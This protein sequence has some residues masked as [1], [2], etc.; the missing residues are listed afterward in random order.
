MHSYF[1]V[2]LLASVDVRTPDLHNIGR[3]IRLSKS[4]KAP[5]IRALV[6]QITVARENDISPT[7]APIGYTC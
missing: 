1:S 2:S 5:D 7:S 6:L 4:E 3:R